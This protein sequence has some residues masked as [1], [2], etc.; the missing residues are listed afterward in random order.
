M[1]T[2]AAQNGPETDSSYT[3]DDIYNRLDSG[4]TGSKGTFLEPAAGPG[5]SSVR[6]SIDD[7]ME[8]APASNDSAASGHNVVQGKT[9]WSL[10][11]NSWGVMTG[12]MPEIGGQYITPS[13]A[14]QG[15]SSGLHDGSGKVYGDT[16]L[17]SSNI[18][19]GVNI[20]GVDGVLTDMV[21]T[22]SADAQADYIV[23]GKTAWVDGMLVTGTLPDPLNRQSNTEEKYVNAFTYSGASTRGGDTV[24]LSGVFPDPVT[25]LSITVGG[26][27]V[28]SS[29]IID[30]ASGQV[31]FISPAGTGSGDIILN[32]D[33]ENIPYVCQTAAA[34]GDF[35]YT[36]SA[37]APWIYDAPVIYT[38]SGCV[39]NGDS[40]EDCL[41]DGSE[42]I[43][44]TGDNFG[45]EGAFISIQIEGVS[46]EN[47]SLIN[48]HTSFSFT[49]PIIPD[50]GNVVHAVV[51]IDGIKSDTSRL[52][53]FM[54][55]EI[56]PFST[57]SVSSVSGGDT[58]VFN[59]RN[60]SPDPADLDVR[61]G[62]PGSSFSEKE[63]AVILFSSM[64]SI[65]LVMPAYAGRQL[66]LTIKKGLQTYTADGEIEYPPPSIIGGG[67][68]SSYSDSGSSLCTLS[69][70]GRSRVY[71]K[72]ENLAAAENMSVHYGP[73]G[74]PFRYSCTDI[75]IPDDSTI[76][77][78]TQKSDSS[79]F[80]FVI[81]ALNSASAE[82]TDVLYFSG[83]A[84]VIYSVSGCRD[85]GSATVDCPACGGSE[86]TLS[87]SG[88]TESTVIAASGKNCPIIDFVDS[89]RIICELPAGTGRVYLTANSAESGLSAP[90][91]VYVEYAAPEI[92]TLSGC[93][94]ALD[95]TTLA[96]S[97]NGG[98]VM[99]LTGNNFGLEGGL[100]YVAGSF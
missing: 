25:S 53:S 49:L 62:L 8:K 37:G 57:V 60:L 82:G 27:A 100:I 98:T 89:S 93:P 20:F 19:S 70:Y 32:I 90:D 30:T 73:L 22:Y 78:V 95:I 59:G 6:K 13:T 52:I 85:T 56:E 64:D 26:T 41:I 66:E 18:K 91:S 99:S 9:F 36:V 31:S 47:I 2:A 24:I 61:I 63:P 33:S 68:R 84:P 44:V 28:P 58:A 69:S 23:N 17:D 40:T 92:L 7:I 5:G 83:V 4:R 34:D 50:G 10:D 43:T 42:V 74:N 14:D 86:I 97:E 88:F 51:D 29:D 80:V 96:C 65:V 72:A 77:C 38:M 35:S 3:L 81:E 1:F 21:N 48:A 55:P 94:T 54:G 39:D 15:I 67:L 87:G 75:E 76:S 45:T 12:T 79:G 16:D 46:A 71:F 11:T